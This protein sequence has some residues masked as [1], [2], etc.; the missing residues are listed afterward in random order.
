MKTFFIAALAVFSIWHFR[1]SAADSQEA[2][3]KDVLAGIEAKD[4]QALERLTISKDDF[5]KHVWPSIAARVSSSNMNADSFYTMY[6]KSSGVG[7][8]Q[9]LS[10]IGGQKLEL[11]RLSPGGVAHETKGARLYSAPEIVV[12]G[13]DGKEHTVRPVGG[14]LEQAGSFKVTTYFVRGAGGTH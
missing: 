11:V 3:L 6:L 8:A 7:L 14:V 2:L 12:R 5:R 4:G 13:A 9:T 1:L 10:A